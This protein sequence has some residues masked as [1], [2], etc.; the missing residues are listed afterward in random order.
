MQQGA[1]RRAEE[2]GQRPR[3][4]CGG[5]FFGFLAT[6]GRSRG[7]RDPQS[8]LPHAGSQ[9]QQVK[10]SPLTKDRT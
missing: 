6:P 7:V 9:L 3:G 4:F 2:R 5:L 10:Y 8:S 1:S